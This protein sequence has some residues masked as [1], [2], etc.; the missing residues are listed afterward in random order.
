MVNRIQNWVEVAPIIFVPYKRGSS[1]PK[2][3]TIIEESPK[4]FEVFRKGCLFVLPICLSFLY[5][6]L[7]YRQ[8][9][10]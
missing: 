2:L 3:E 4:N 6:V 9:S 10:Y 8:Y 7:L 1:S 5:Y